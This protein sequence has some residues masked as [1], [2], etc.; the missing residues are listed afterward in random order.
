MNI[1]FNINGGIGKS[2]VAT[3]VCKAIKKKY[4]NSTLIVL[5]GYP[6]V[7]S[8]SKDVDMS[9][10]F[11]QEAYFYTKYVENK[12]VMIMANEPYNVTEHIL[13][14]EHLIETWCKMYD[15]P[16]NGEQPEI[17]INE[18]E[19]MF[20]KQKYS[21]DKPIMLIQTNGGAAGQELKYS[22]ARDIPRHIVEK[23]IKEFSPQYNIIHARREDQIAFE[24]T[25]SVTDSFKGMAVLCEMSQ[26]RFFMDSFLQHTAAA[27]E[28]PSTVCWVA[29]SPK[30]FGYDIHDNILANPFTAKPDLK[31]S[32]FSKFNIIGLLEEFPYNNES[33]IFSEE[34][35]IESLKQQG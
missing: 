8:N 6:E 25:Y 23:V 27:L 11:G 20:Y 17:I 16:Y 12:D 34:K 33:E 3:A 9:Y 18:R 19:R 22:W 15:I 31:N 7:F 30:I 29:N 32:V 13:S 4:P 10:G 2:I 24:N 35:I 5:S 1:V 26:K 21:S 14:Q 28:K